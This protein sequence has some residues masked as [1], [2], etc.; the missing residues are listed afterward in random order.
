MD[1]EVFLTWRDVAKIIS[2]Y[3]C[4]RFNWPDGAEFEL[5][6]GE[7]GLLV[8]LLKPDGDESREPV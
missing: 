3:M 1:N 7:N 5:I 2:P 8:R 6:N 4:A